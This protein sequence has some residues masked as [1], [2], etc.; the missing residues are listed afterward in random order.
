[1]KSYILFFLLLLKFNEICAQLRSIDSCVSFTLE[2][3]DK[4][5]I[6]DTLKFLYYDCQKVYTD[7]DTIILINGKAS[8]SGKINRATEGIL[9]FPKNR[10]MDGPGVLRFII[11]PANMKLIFSSN[12]GVFSNVVIQNSNSQTEKMNWEAN[13]SH[14]QNSEKYYNELIKMDQQHD[15]VINNK[16]RQIIIDTIS[17]LKNLL[18]N[19]ALLYIKSNPHSYFSAYLLSRYHGS[20]PTD[21]SKKYFQFLS[22]SVAYSDF[23]KIVLSNIYK[24]TDDWTFREAFS[25][26]NYYRTL[27]K[28]NNIYDISLPNIKGEKIS[29]SRFK[30]KFILIDF[31]GSWCHPCFENIPYLKKLIQEMKNEPIEFITVSIDEHEKIWKTSLKKYGFPGINLWD[32]DGLLSTFFKVLWVPRYIIIKPDGNGASI[33]AP[34]AKDP[35]LKI[36]LFDLLHNEKK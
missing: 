1:M 36:L 35:E 6:S 29:L 34:Q 13:N 5:H 15:K 14:F 21:T 19:D 16:N 33:D 7:R 10:L 26:T 12:N 23:G 24:T 4:N 30:G 9:Y 11:E 28:I 31:W 32:K 17:M 2:I 25:D 20:L 8:F 3:E 18:I 22:S 27:K